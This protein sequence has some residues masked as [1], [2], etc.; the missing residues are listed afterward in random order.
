MSPILTPKDSTKDQSSNAISRREALRLCG[1]GA[2]PAA[3]M[4]PTAAAIAG[5]APKP[6]RTVIL[7]SRFAPMPDTVSDGVQEFVDALESRSRLKISCASPSFGTGILDA[8]N[9][10]QVDL[11]IDVLTLQ[12]SGIPA[13]D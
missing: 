3:G 13:L 1:M 12:K 4:L 11:G 6:P 9:A 5:P 2:I 8:V 10:G 7:D